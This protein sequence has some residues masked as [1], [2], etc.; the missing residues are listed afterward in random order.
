MEQRLLEV[1][2]NNGVKDETIQILIEDEVIECIL[3]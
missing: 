2:T 3:T 1:L